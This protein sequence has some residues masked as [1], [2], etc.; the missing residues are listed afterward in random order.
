[1]RDDFRKGF[2]GDTS[3]WQ[4]VA[5]RH[6]GEDRERVQK[7]SVIVYGPKE[8]GPYVRDDFRIGLEVVIG[9]VSRHVLSFGLLA[10]NSEWYLVLADQP[11]KDALLLAQN[12]MVVKKGK[13]IVSRA[14]R[15]QK[16]VHGEGPLGPTIC[17]KYHT[18]KLV[19]Q[20]SFQ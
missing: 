2:G 13:E 8:G 4:L 14:F 19:K 9:P 16:P 11:S 12:V 3:Q 18:I 20:Q 5:G 6:K 15:R 10:K 1:M 7:V 17:P